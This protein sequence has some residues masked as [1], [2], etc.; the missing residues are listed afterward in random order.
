MTDIDLGL[1]SEFY[2]TKVWLEH[3]IQVELVNFCNLVP[4]L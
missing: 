3:Q 2:I 1:S 4:M